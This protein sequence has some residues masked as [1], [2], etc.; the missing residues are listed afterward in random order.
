MFRVPSDQV[1]Q[2]VRGCYFEVGDPDSFYMVVL[3]GPLPWKYG[4][5]R[6]A[7]RITQ[8]VACGR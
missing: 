7:R 1:R 3:G 5:V 6:S 4:P 2:L 8:E